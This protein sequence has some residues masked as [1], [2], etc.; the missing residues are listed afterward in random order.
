M[1][2]SGYDE[3]EDDQAYE[4]QNHLFNYMEEFP[5]MKAGQDEVIRIGRS[6]NMF[7]TIAISK[8]NRVYIGC[9]RSGKYR[10][11]SSM[12]VDVITR[13][14][15]G[16]KKNE[17]PFQLKMRRT[18]ENGPWIERTSENGGRHNHSLG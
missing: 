16:T 10:G 17:C 15:S 11:A 1:Y 3:E 13:N 2:E 18:G 4:D 9:E 7:F 12:N 5:T 6:T 8:K 14:S